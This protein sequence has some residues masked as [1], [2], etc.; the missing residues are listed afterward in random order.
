MSRYMK[1]WW[2]EISMPDGKEWKGWI[3]TIADRKEYF[4]EKLNGRFWSFKG[5]GYLGFGSYGL[6]ILDGQTEEEAKSKSQ[7]VI[8]ALY[9]KP[10]VCR[11]YYSYTETKKALDS[12][13]PLPFWNRI[14]GRIEDCLN[15]E[16]TYIIEV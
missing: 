6:F 5:E 9:P 4:P 1:K 13:N 14:E 11:D 12:L 7:Y 15:L 2:L 3:N 8:G 10:Y 16:R